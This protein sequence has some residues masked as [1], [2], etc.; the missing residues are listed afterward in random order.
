MYDAFNITMSF[1]YTVRHR[2]P[3]A[4][5][6][7]RRAS[8]DQT[9]LWGSRLDVPCESVADSFP[10]GEISVSCAE[11]RCSFLRSRASFISG[12]TKLVFFVA[13]PP[14]G[15]WAVRKDLRC[16]ILAMEGLDFATSGGTCSN[17]D[18]HGQ[19]AALYSTTPLM[20]FELL[21]ASARHSVFGQPFKA[22]GSGSFKL[23]C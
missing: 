2:A 14:P 16:S 20:P 7:R 6:L 8:P 21:V 17:K 9:E 10:S 11:W 23:G 3:P 4:T 22:G 15:A 5:S 18:E 12:Q 13:Q 19:A 1:S